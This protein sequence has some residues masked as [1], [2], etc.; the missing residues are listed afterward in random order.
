MLI[1]ISEQKV[2]SNTEIYLYM[3]IYLEMCIFTATVPNPQSIIV[4]THIFGLSWQRTCCRPNMTFTIGAP[5][6]DSL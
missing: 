4:G 3:Y 2:N 6:Q 5:G 1:V